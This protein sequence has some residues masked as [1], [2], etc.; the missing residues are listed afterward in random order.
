[1]SATLFGVPASHPSL[2]A[3]LM[4]RHKGI[5]YRRVDLISVLH[6]V[7]VR[8]LGFPGPTVPALRLDG[9]RLQGTRDISLA[10]DA[11]RP[12]PPLF[13]EDPAARRPVLEA[14]AWGDSV[15]Q[16][17]ARRVIWAGLKRDRSTI[18]SYLEGARTGIPPALAAHTAAPVVAAAVRANNASDDQVHRDLVELPRLL[19]RVDELLADGVIG[20]AE[21]NA[22]D[23]Q[24]ATSAA[25]LA[26]M[27]DLRPLMEGRPV[28]EHA[29]RVAP[30]YPGRLPR[31]FP[32]S[33]LP[34]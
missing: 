7:L 5:E 17:V 27:E 13:P 11:L 22:A 23:F 1:M 8:G 3:E 34:G 14:E 2:A 21:L 28:L 20:G 19:D 16:P 25:L 6:R 10:L 15:L 4:L 31:V 29:G 24:I 32:A 18:A 30:S 9:A 33:W 26:S 12:R